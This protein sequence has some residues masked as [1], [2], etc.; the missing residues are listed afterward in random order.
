MQYYHIGGGDRSVLELD[1][2]SSK[3]E[4]EGIGYGGGTLGYLNLNICEE[5]FCLFRALS[6]IPSPSSQ[7]LQLKET[8]PLIK[9]GGLITSIR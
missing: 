1:T 6:T 3:L 5:W 4:K 9:Q 8:R 2:R 7:G